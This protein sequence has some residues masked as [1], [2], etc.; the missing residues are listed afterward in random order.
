VV[1]LPTLVL[2]DSQGV[3]RTEQSPV[4]FVDPDELLSDLRRVR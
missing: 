1:A 3:A 2:V 4:G